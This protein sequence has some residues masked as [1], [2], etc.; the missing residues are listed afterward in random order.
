MTK[1]SATD[2]GG[3][4]ATRTERKKA[5]LAAIVHR[6]APGSCIEKIDT[7]FRAQIPVDSQPICRAVVTDKDEEA[8]LI[9]VDLTITN[10][11]GETRVL[12]T[13]CFRL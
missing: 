12:G 13:A 9:E 1:S 10:E 5:L 7:V 2:N 4:P 3:V 6:W 8:G 11:A